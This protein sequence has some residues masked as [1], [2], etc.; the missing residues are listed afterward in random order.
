MTDS[1]HIALFGGSFN[2]IHN[3]HVALARHVLRHCPVDEVWLMVSPHNPLKEPGELLP[4]NVRY[5]LAAKALEGESGIRASNFE[6]SLPRPSYTWRTLQALEQQYPGCR[7]SLL[8]GADNWCVF[9][10]WA[11]SED[12]LASHSLFV[13]PRPGYPLSAQTLPPNVHLV[14]APLFPFS[15]TDVRRNVRVGEDIRPMVPEAILD[16]VMKL[17]NP[18]PINQ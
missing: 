15:S 8:I 11:H 3:G 9:S 7:F 2:P 18:N 6:F 13:Y 12:I 4:E 10:R 17:Y 16:D 14:N 1:R 5:R